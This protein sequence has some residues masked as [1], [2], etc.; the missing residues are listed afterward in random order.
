MVKI[1]NFVIYKEIYKDIVEDFE[2][3]FDT[4]NFEIDRPLP[5]EKNKRV[6][7]PI[8]DDLGEQIRKEFVG[9]R[10]KTHSYL[11]DNSDKDKKTK[12]IKKCTI[13]TRLKFQD[14]K[15][16]LKAIEIEKKELFR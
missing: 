1:Q 3:R 10:A 16:C 5:K 7:G 13:K 15:S 12:A 8:K 2:I 11:K 6:I 9:L 14:Y 4:Y